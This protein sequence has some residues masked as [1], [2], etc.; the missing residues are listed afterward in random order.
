MTDDYCQVCDK[1]FT[2]EIHSLAHYDGKSHAKKVRMVTEGHG[3]DASN[4]N[5]FCKQCK[6]QFTNKEMAQAHYS[7]KVHAKKLNELL[8]MNKEDRNK[9]STA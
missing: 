6:C 9:R 8:G 7:G 5:E 3:G 4:P 2:S 1:A